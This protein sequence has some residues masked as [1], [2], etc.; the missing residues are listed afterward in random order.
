MTLFRITAAGIEATMKI[1]SVA[2]PTTVLLTTLLFVLLAQ[3]EN[4]ML[5]G[6]ENT[7]EFFI[8]VPPEFLSTIHPFEVLPNNFAPTTVL[9]VPCPL[10]I[11][12][13][14]LR[15][16]TGLITYELSKSPAAL[17]MPAHPLLK[18]IVSLITH[19]FQLTLTPSLVL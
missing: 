8:L 7:N 6:F 2:P 16:L 15:K 5:L 4:L 11:P 14:E 1:P 17:P 12:F 3:S 9:F 10:E 13:C 18:V 19:P